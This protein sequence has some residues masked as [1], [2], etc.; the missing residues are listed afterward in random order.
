[1]K[2]VDRRTFLKLAGSGTVAVA[3]ATVSGSAMLLPTTS[4]Q[5]AFRASTGLPAKPMPSM[6]TKIVE[7]HVDLAS[8]TGIVNSRVLVGHPQPSQIALPGLSRLIR[9]TSAT[10]QG[11]IVR[12]AGVVDD[13]SQLQPGEPPT[14]QITIDRE[15]G[16]VTAPLAGH[17]VTLTLE[18]LPA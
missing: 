2:R 10:E 1:M 15:R 9:I 3:A 14:F 17:N 11:G 7:G 5:L 4:R 12:L 16:V 18:E 13:R 8:G 6:V